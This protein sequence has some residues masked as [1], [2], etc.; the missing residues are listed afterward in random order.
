MFAFKIGQIYMSNGYI[1]EA[2][3]YDVKIQFQKYTIDSLLD[4]EV[5]Y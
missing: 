2:C 5:H 3:V 1:Y 4:F